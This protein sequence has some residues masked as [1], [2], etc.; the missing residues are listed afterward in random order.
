M[1]SKNIH[2]KRR[3]L[4]GRERREKAELLKEHTQKWHEINGAL[5]A[6]CEALGPHEWKYLD[7]VGLFREKVWEICRDC[8]MTRT[9]QFC[10]AYPEDT[11]EEANGV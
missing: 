9:R 6:E 2:A 8:G 3:E 10:K 4:E 5:H 1:S 11:W 7:T